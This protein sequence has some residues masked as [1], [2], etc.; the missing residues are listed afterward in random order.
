MSKAYS[1]PELRCFGSVAELTA[2]SFNKVGFASD[3]F[4]QL[5]NGVVIGSLVTPH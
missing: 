5:T 3:I 1:K 4:T 2:G